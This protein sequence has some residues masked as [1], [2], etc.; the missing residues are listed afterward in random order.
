MAVRVMS[1]LS[2]SKWE[3]KME[4]YKSLGWSHDEL[5]SAFRAQPNCM[6]SSTEKIR[7]LMNFFVNELGLKPSVLSKWPNL[8]LLS[9]DKRI[10]PRCSVLQILLSKGLVKSDLNI[11]SV[12][13]QNK[14]HFLKHYVIKFQENVPDVLKAYGGE[15]GFERVSWV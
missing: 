15:I 7:M 9:L 14:T 4:V 12:L 2:K 10:V 11:C 6:V 5:L 3:H 8:L 1:C 13:N